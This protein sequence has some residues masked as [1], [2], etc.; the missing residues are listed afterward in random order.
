MGSAGHL[1]CLNNNHGPLGTIV[2]AG[3]SFRDWRLF[4]RLCFTGFHFGFVTGDIC[5]LR[6]PCV[7][8]RS[9]S[10]TCLVQPIGTILH[11]G[12]F[13]EYYI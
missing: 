7:R 9:T 6:Y 10:M 8:I 2:G 11:V 13:P 3:L 5:T 4:D 12:A 1:W